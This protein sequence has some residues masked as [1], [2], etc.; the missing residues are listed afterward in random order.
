[1]LVFLLHILGYDLWFY[2]SH[3]MLH[4]STLWPIH[5]V[6]HERRVPTWPDTYHGHWLESPLQGL[7]FLLP[8]LL[9]AP[10]WWQSAA[11]LLFVNARGMARH[12]GRTAPWIGNHHMLHHEA[13][14]WNYGEYWLDRLF[15]TAYPHQEKVIRGTIYL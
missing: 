13:G 1:M 6:H 4:L 10:A 11:A 7:G 9:L 8:W 15:G 14:A 2:A 12:D 5:K 3:R